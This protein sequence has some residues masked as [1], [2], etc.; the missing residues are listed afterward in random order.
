MP[1]I[2]L[3]TTPTQWSLGWFI[4]IVPGVARDGAGFCRPELR[5]QGRTA[6]IRLH[7][8]H[9]SRWPA[10]LFLSFQTMEDSLVKSFLVNYRTTAWGVASIVGAI[11]SFVVALTDNSPET[12]P[13]VL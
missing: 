2:L 7:P 5:R 9:L 4:C 13:D 11:A 3:K 1:A 12:V 10:V 6:G 8:F